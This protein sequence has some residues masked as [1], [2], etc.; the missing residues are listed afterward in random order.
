MLY[1]EDVVTFCCQ[2]K[3]R[4]VKALIDYL[5]LPDGG[6]SSGHYWGILG[7]HPGYEHL[8]QL[9]RNYSGQ[10]VRRKPKPALKFAKTG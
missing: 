7:G 8:K 5:V 2:L 10:L 3:K 6:F 9:Q 1:K 4:F